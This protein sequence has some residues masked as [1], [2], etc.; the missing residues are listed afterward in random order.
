MRD[1]VTPPEQFL[2][3]R[4]PDPLVEAHGF[5]VNSIYT[6]TVL[7]PILGPSATLCLRRLGTW[8]ALS[9]DGIPVNTRQ[10]ACDL[11]LGSGLGRNAPMSRTL[12][13]LCQFDLAHWDNHELAVRTA[14]GPLPERHLRRLS[15]PVLAVHQTLLNQTARNGHTHPPPTAARSV[16]PLEATCA[17]RHGVDL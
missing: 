3:R 2:V 12:N 1:V 16:E 17:S 7:L 15:P 10:L 9:P 14:V 13:R 5:P 4:W 11:G 8:A 6:E